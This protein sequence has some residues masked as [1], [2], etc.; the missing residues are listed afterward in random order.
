MSLP[1]TSTHEHH[2][3]NLFTTDIRLYVWNNLRMAGRKLLKFGID[4]MPQATATNSFLQSSLPTLLLL[5]L[6]RWNN[7]TITHD[8]L[9]ITNP[10]K[11]FQ[12][13]PNLTLPLHN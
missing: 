11:P 4:V 10:T 8:P 3:P 6:A 1:T 2:E 7:D 9:R 5:K 12:T 13:S